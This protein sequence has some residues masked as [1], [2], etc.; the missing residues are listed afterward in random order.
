M[1]SFS[2]RICFFSFFVHNGSSSSNTTNRNRATTPY[3]PRQQ[4]HTAV[5]ST[6]GSTGGRQRKQARMKSKSS[7]HEK[8][9]T[10]RVASVGCFPGAW[11]RGSWHFQVAS[12]HLQSSM[13][14]SFSASHYFSF[15]SKRSGWRMPP[16]ERSALYV[17]YIPGR[18][19]GMRPQTLTGIRTDMKTHMNMLLA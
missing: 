19:I 6:S 2:Q 7:M 12:L 14:F 17:L 18:P 1:F 3:Y 16:A 13:G 4:V 8:R 9:G 5:R 15:L 11:R 10:T